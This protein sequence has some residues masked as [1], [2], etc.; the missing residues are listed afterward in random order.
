MEDH[1]H[2]EQI[3][4]ESDTPNGSSG[5][6]QVPSSLLPTVLQRLGLTAEWAH[7]E[8]SLEDLQAQ[9][10]SDDWMTRARA[11]R[12]LGRLNAAVAIELLLS[13]LDD[14]DGS[15]RAAAVQALG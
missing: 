10:K 14:Q 2:E 11:V 1:E 15:V 5:Y 4:Q 6:A 9:L 13:A 7:S 8:P 3:S 12:T